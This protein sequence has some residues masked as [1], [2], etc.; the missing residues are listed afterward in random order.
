M[1]KEEITKQFEEIKTLLKRKEDKPL[2]FK[3]ACAYLGYAPSYLYKLT[4]TGKIPN[5][6]PSGKMLFFSK[7]EL[8]DWVFGRYGLGVKGETENTSA[9]LSAGVKR[10]MQEARSKK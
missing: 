5:Y 1:R 8:D 6:K 10:E 7:T 9:S 3:E 4:S 2:S